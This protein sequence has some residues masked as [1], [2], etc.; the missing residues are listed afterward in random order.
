M[1]LH[2]KGY[3]KTEIELKILK[4]F[5]MYDLSRDDRIKDL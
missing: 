2:E 5:K 3:T 1:D 4:F